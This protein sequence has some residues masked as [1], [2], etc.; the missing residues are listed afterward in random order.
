MSASA[1]VSA[2]KER[3]PARMSVELGTGQRS[4][5]KNSG[6][7]SCRSSGGRLQIGPQ[8]KGAVPPRKSP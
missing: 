2:S 7:R 5:R 6:V 3:A 4:S 8:R 1:S